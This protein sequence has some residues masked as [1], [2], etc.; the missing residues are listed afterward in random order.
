MQTDAAI[1]PGNSGGP[2]ARQFRPAHRRDDGNLLPLGSECRHRLRRSGP[3][4]SAGWCPQNHRTGRLH[5]APGSAVEFRPQINGLAPTQWPSG[6]VLVLGVEPGSA[7]DRAGIVAR[8]GLSAGR[9][10]PGDAIVPR[11]E[12]ASGSKPQMTS[13]PP[14]DLRL[15]GDNGHRDGLERDG[16]RREPSAWQTFS[17][18][19]GARRFSRRPRRPA[20]VPGNSK[21]RVPMRY[22]PSETRLC[23]T[24]G[25]PGHEDR[26][27]DLI[28]GEIEGPLRRG[29]DRRDGP[30]LICRR[31]GKGK[32][33]QKV[34]LLCHMDE[35]GFLVSPPRL[36]QGLREPPARGAVS[37][38]A[39]SSPGGFGSAPER[40]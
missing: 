21:G 22:R 3:P 37:T 15:P 17:I 1:N 40:A 13:W 39:T 20:R 27:R 6:G 33:P 9:I 16:A 34:M 8:H 5:I 23:E 38:R 36:R 4:R 30:S 31:A 29:R 26:V 14:L 18:P 10:A 25:V 35:I 19:P 24:P 7:A 2:L 12:W 11:S 28:A 32:D